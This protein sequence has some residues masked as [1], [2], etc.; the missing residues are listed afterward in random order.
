MNPGLSV[1][2][3]KVKPRTLLRLSEALSLFGRL[4]LSLR[5]HNPSTE[6]SHHSVCSQSLNRVRSFQQRAQ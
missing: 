1:P 6:D 5:H 2:I 3:Q 4:P